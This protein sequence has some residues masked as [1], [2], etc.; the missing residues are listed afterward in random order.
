[1]HLFGS[2]VSGLAALYSDVDV[3]LETPWEDRLNGVSNMFVLAGTL[4]KHGMS[5]GHIVNSAKVPVCRFFDSEYGI[6]CDINVNNTIALRNTEL[7]RSYVAIDP[8]VRKLCVL[9]KHWAKRR[10]LNDGMFFFGYSWISFTDA[11]RIVSPIYLKHSAAK[12]GTL[13][14]Y[15]WVMLIINF[16][17]T[18]TPS[19]LPSLHAMYDGPPELS[20]EGVDTAFYTDIEALKERKYGV[21]NTESLG[22]LFFRFFRRF[23]IE[24]DYESSVVSVR[25]GAFLYKAEKGWDVEMARHNNF[26]AVEEPFNPTRNLANSA[27]FYSVVGLRGEFRRTFEILVAGG[28]LEQVNARYVFPGDSPQTPD[29]DMQL[30]LQLA[31][32]LFPGKG[33]R[34]NPPPKKPSPAPQPSTTGSGET[35]N[36][37][38]SPAAV[39][40]STSSATPPPLKKVV[41]AAAQ[42][43]DSAVDH[44]SRSSSLPGMEFA[45]GKDGVPFVVQAN[46]YHH[47][48]YRFGA[49]QFGMDPY[50]SAGYLLRS[51]LALMGMPYELASYYHSTYFD[52]QHRYLQL[53]DPAGTRRH[54]SVDRMARNAGSSQFM[55]RPLKA[56][57]PTESASP[58][59]R[60]VENSGTSASRK[61]SSSGT[62]TDTLSEPSDGSSSPRPSESLTAVSVST[63]DVVDIELPPSAARRSSDGP[64]ISPAS[65]SIES[66]RESISVSSVASRS[67]SPPPD[68]QPTPAEVF[69]ISTSPNNRKQQK[70]GVLLWTNSSVKTSS[71][72]AMAADD[73]F[74]P[75]PA[76]EKSG[77]K[78]RDKE[79]RK[80]TSDAPNGTSNVRNKTGSTPTRSSAT[81][82]GRDKEK[83]DRDSAKEMR[84]KQKAA[85]FAAAATNSFA[86]LETPRRANV[87]SAV[88]PSSKEPAPAA[89][90]MSWAAIVATKSA[91]DK[92]GEKAAPDASVLSKIL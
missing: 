42:G 24:F 68:N 57:P 74:A 9:I 64:S 53:P 73:L 79:K 46:P 1:M 31:G 20:A 12:G 86:T 37:A 84:P 28:S 26:F 60:A 16:L 18:R 69:R 72:M 2:S 67:P 3:C 82:G 6:Y 27:D 33:Y 65:D 14:S 59:L 17:Q 71:A 39:A 88:S 4:R 87:N 61:D 41:G 50:Y 90:A 62:A 36:A 23:A 15:C 66:S 47:I 81:S 25:T 58:P 55:L 91:G 29:S 80:G 78:D 40:G 11:V 63:L 70:K 48:N 49:P 22:A 52:R 34:N 35:G 76:A 8:R 38:P 43:I 21:N 77:N 13:S 32:S 89:R 56:Q 92:G 5:I 83:S 51:D 10:A 45:V 44:H 54:S 85:S 75:K 19:I 30:H 7:V